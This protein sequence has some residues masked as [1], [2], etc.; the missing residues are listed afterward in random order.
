MP[1][2]LSKSQTLAMNWLSKGW[3]AYAI[4]GGRVEVNGMKVGTVATMESLEK[5]GLVE[6]LGVSAWNATE[7]GKGWSSL[8]KPGN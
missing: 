6:R 5:L 8:P 2:K 1:S 7:A 3:K 4:P